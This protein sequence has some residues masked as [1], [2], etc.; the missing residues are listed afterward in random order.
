MLL[1]SAGAGGI[2]DAD[3]GTGGPGGPGGPG[4]RGAIGIRGEQRPDAPAGVQGPHGQA[5]LAGTVT[6]LQLS[7][8][9]FWTAVRGDLGPALDRSIE[10][11]LA[12]AEFAYRQVRGAPTPF[13]LATIDSLLTA[14]IAA[15]PGHPTAS[16]LLAQLRVGDSVFGLPR[17]LDVLPD[18]DR[19]EADLRAYASWLDPLFND[20]KL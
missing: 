9:A 18:F 10:H 11:W 2:V 13:Q 19:V 7:G 14:V 8:T 1:W 17:T 15:A 20:A 4:G 3:G 5:G 6:E 16:R 12:C